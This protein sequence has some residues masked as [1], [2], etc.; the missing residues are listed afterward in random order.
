MPVSPKNASAHTREYSSEYPSRDGVPL[1]GK[2]G[3]LLET[4][5]AYRQGVAYH[6]EQTAGHEKARITPQYQAAIL[7]SYALH[8]LQDLVHPDALDV[9]LRSRQWQYVCDALDIASQSEDPTQPPEIND[10]QMLGIATYL[11]SLSANEGPVKR[12]LG[13]VG[14]AFRR[15]LRK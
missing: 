13:E 14:K 1:E 11:N 2:L 10:Y 12:T 15:I 5:A 3:L 8:V 9:S 6:I 7:T 4:E